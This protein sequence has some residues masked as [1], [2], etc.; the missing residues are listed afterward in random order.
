MSRKVNTEGQSLILL[1]R[2]I[3][4]DEGEEGEEEGRRIKELEISENRS[5]INKYALGRYILFYINPHHA[6]VENIVSSCQR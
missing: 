1:S 2:S 6:N 4:E 3:E 5:S